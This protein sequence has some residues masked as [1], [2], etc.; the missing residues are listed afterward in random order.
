[1]SLCMLCCYG[2][3][4]RHVEA[5]RTMKHAELFERT[6][7]S[8]FQLT[9]L[10]SNSFL[11][12]FTVGWL[13]V[14]QTTQFSFFFLSSLA[15]MFISGF[16]FIRDSSSSLVHATRNI[17]CTLSK[18]SVIFFKWSA[19]FTSICKPQKKVMATSKFI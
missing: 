9:Q 12:E 15:T 17:K 13:F 14:G 11:V 7:F 10:E 18:Y 3:L 5:T 6:R 16:P 4:T 8:D 1:M 19:Y 2:M